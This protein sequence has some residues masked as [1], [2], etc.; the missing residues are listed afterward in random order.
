MLQHQRRV[1]ATILIA[2]LASGISVYVPVVSLIASLFVAAMVYDLA[3]SLRSNRARMNLQSPTCFSEG[4]RG[5][6][7]AHLPR[8]TRLSCLI[9]PPNRS[10][11]PSGLPVLL[12]AEEAVLGDTK[13]RTSLRSSLKGFGRPRSASLP[14]WA[15]QGAPVTA[16]TFDVLY[17]TYVYTLS[18]TVTQCDT[19]SSET[20]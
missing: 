16:L 12:P 7:R 19:V 4:N 8:R 15:C 20:L 10:G 11:K 13:A 1:I 18:H 3:R 14:W 9:L 5:G 6:R 2:L 17:Y